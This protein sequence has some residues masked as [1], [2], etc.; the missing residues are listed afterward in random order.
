V[1]VGWMAMTSPMVDAAE[2]HRRAHRQAAH[3]FGEAQVVLAPCGLLE[4]LLAGGNRRKAFGGGGLG[5]AG[6]RGQEGQAAGQDG[7][8]G[9][10]IDLHA[11]G[12]ELDVHAAGVPEAGV[13]GHEAVVGRLDEDAHLDPLA[14]S[15]R[16][17][18]VTW[19]A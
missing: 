10:G 18:P 5:G 3:R 4:G 7:G 17:K 12:A 9:F 1:D 2:I 13:G 6:V 11:V 8:E 14:V 16:R 19:P 15:S